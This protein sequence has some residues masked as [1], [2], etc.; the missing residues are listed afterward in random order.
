MSN[1]IKRKIVFSD[2]EDLMS[3][4]LLNGVVDLYGISLTNEQL[5]NLYSYCKNN[6]PYSFIVQKVDTS[7]MFLINNI[8]E[9]N[10]KE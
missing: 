2:I 9:S 8:E 5:N 10:L 3:C 7:E 6:Y 4:C 1:I